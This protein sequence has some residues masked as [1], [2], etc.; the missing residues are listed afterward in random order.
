MRQRYGWS[1]TRILSGYTQF[2]AAVQNT[3]PK[4]FGKPGVDTVN[5]PRQC[6]EFVSSFQTYDDSLMRKA[7]GSPESCS[8][9]DWLAVHYFRRELADHL[10]DNPWEPIDEEGVPQAHEQFVKLSEAAERAQTDISTIQRWINT[11]MPHQK[12]GSKQWVQ[13]SVVER[14]VKMKFRHKAR[15][16]LTKRRL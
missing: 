8:Q 4:G 3:A 11:G 5:K 2:I 14:W 15:R 16:N 7:F 12:R 6:F 9:E 1:A 13:M 10:R